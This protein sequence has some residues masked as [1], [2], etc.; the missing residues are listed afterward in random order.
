MET[1][2]C[3]RH[4]KPRQNH[5]DGELTLRLIRGSSTS[6]AVWMALNSSVI[7]EA[8]A[9]AV[10]N[11]RYNPEPWYH[12]LVAAKEPVQQQAVRDGKSARTSQLI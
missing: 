6:R 10:Y 12:G 3:L 1:S 7:T 8:L 5:R 9:M 2:V 4:S 11:P